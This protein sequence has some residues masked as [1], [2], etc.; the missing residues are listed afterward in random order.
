MKYDLLLEYF[1][2]TND[3]WHHYACLIVDGKIIETYID[4]KIII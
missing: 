4:G 2:K 3:H 1:K